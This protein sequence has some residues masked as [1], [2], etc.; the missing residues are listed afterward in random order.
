M[1]RSSIVSSSIIV[2]AIASLSLAIACS[3]STPQD[4][5]EG[6]S[7]YTDVTTVT[8]ETDDAIDLGCPPAPDTCSAD[9][10]GLAEE[11]APVFGSMKT[12]ADPPKSWQD[13]CVDALKGATAK[14]AKAVKICV[15]TVAVCA[16]LFGN[17]NGTEIQKF[18]AAA[19]KTVSCKGKAEEE[20]RKIQDQVCKSCAGTTACADAGTTPTKR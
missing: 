14:T 8:A 15:H 2:A 3:A 11:E 19:S 5:G 4:T 17:A 18:C 10:A 12:M 1:I 6:S 7:A 9:D 20:S 13:Q 16:A